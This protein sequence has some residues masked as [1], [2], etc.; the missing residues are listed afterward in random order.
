MRLQVWK[1]SIHY[2]NY[3]NAFDGMLLYDT[4]N[5]DFH[6]HINVDSGKSKI[7]NVEDLHLLTNLDIFS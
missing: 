1:R 2:D 6:I 5:K 3:E 7:L 4:D